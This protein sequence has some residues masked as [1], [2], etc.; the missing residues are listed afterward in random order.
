MFILGLGSVSHQLA[1]FLLLV[2]FFLHCR[3]HIYTYNFVLFLGKRLLTLYAV[4]LY[5]TFS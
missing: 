3:S 4:I 5:F 1:I 2:F